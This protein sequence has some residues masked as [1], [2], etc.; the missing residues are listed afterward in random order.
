MRGEIPGA[1][2]GARSVVD[3][4]R[5]GD[6]G[7]RLPLCR[8]RGRGQLP[9]FDFPAAQ[10]TNTGSWVAGKS[11]KVFSG[12]GL[13]KRTWTAVAGRQ[14]LPRY[15]ASP[16]AG[17]ATELLRAVSERGLEGRSGAAGG[18]GPP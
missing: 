12:S 5:T 9:P 17:V 8:L 14:V 3:E 4:V 11:P 1:R 18:R 13:V 6:K 7:A 10:A 16:S 2:E 15:T